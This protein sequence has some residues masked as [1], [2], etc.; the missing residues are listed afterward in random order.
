MKFIFGILIGILGV[1]AYAY[2]M[3][4]ISI[5][6]NTN[7][8]LDLCQQQSQAECV[9]IAMPDFMLQEL[10]SPGTLFEGGNF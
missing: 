4:F 7:K 8:T 9:L 1:V 3:G 6:L 10:F 2:F 5:V